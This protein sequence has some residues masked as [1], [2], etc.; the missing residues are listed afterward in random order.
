[1]ATRLGRDTGGISSAG[2]PDLDWA[3]VP[4]PLLLL[5]LQAAWHVTYD[6]EARP[7]VVMPADGIVNKEHAPTFS[8]DTS[9]RR[10]LFQGLELQY[11]RKVPHRRHVGATDDASSTSSKWAE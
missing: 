2:S 5:L 10:L 11:L 3:I 6:E 8:P 4:P 1:M 7:Y 9:T